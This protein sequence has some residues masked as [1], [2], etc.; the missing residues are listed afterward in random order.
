MAR[1]LWSGSIAFGLL[2]VPVKMYAAIADHRLH[3]TYIHEPDGGSIGYRKYCK[4]EDEIVDDSEIVKAFEYKGELI[5]MRDEDF[6]T[7]AAESTHKTLDVRDFVDLEAIDPS[8]FERSYY[9]AADKGAER[10]YA[11]L[12]QAME[13]CGK[14]AIAKFVMRERQNLA[15]LRSRDGVLICERMHFADEVRPAED[16]R[17]EAEAPSDRELQIARSLIGEL[18]GDFEPEK[19]ADTYRDALCEI[20]ESKSA[21][22]AI[23]PA[24]AEEDKGPTPDLMAALEASLADVRGGAGGRAGNGGSASKRPKGGNDGGA[25]NGDLAGLSKKELYERAKSADLPGRAEMSKDELVE[26]LSG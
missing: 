4:A 17:P 23:E 11:L 25:G 21:G 15:C 26:A 9:L 6:E 5:P 12:A 13:E 16:H 14:A 3:F 7:A 24:R 2:N 1:A 10:A 22:E 18:S 8:Y 20:I 19:Y